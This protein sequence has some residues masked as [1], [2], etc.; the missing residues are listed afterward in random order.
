MLSTERQGNLGVS[1]TGYYLSPDKL[2]AK[3]TPILIYMVKFYEDLYFVTF[4][5][6]LR[7]SVAK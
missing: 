3:A 6:H 7:V 1:Y 4:C 2:P 5:L